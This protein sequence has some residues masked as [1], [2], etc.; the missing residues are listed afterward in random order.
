MALFWKTEK[1]L[2]GR[3]LTNLRILTPSLTRT[4]TRGS[5]TYDLLNTLLRCRR[6]PTS[7]SVLL[8]VVSP[9]A[10]V[11]SFLSI[12]SLVNPAFAPRTSAVAPAVAARFLTCLRLRVTKTRVK[13]SE[14]IRAVLI[15][16][17]LAQHVFILLRKYRQGKCFPHPP[18]LSV[19]ELAFL[20]W[21]FKLWVRTTSPRATNTCFRVDAARV[22]ALRVGTTITRTS[23]SRTSLWTLTLL[24]LLVKT[25]LNVLANASKAL[26]NRL[27]R[28]VRRP[29]GLLA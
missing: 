26:E 29:S 1:N 25:L 3:S 20:R 2:L 14:C 27:E 18:I 8:L 16:T 23:L 21:Q 11:A 6:P 7:V 12:T 15:V 9:S 10:S 17:W 13:L 22:D 5:L 19:L 28:Q 4:S 24:E